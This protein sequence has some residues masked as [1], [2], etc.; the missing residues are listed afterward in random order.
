MK[1]YI[2]VLMMAVAAFTFLSAAEVYDSP[3]FAPVT[4]E[5]IGQGGAFT[6]V[7]HGYNALFTNPAGF[8]NEGGSF[9]LL[10]TTLSPY[11]FPTQ[12]VMDGVSG[13][14]FS[15][16]PDVFLKDAV[17]VLDD[18][19]RNNGL[20][21]NINAGMAIVGKGLGL[22]VV[23]DFDIYAR[24]KNALGTEVDAAATVAAIAGLAF[25][26]DLGT[27]MKLLVGGDIRAMHRIEMR[28]VTISE[29]LDY[30]DETKNT[31]L[32]ALQGSGFAV[33]LGTILKWGGLSFGVS[34]RDL[35]GTTFSYQ[36]KTLEQVQSQE[37]GIDVAD[38]Y[39]IP[40]SINTGIGWHPNLGILRWL[41]DPTFQVDYEHVFYEEKD[42][43]FWTGLH[44]GTEI[45]VLRFI[46]V[47]GG[48]NQGYVTAGLGM[49][50]L[51]LDVNAS[52]F[53][54]EMGIYSGAKPNQGLTL[55]AAIRF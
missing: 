50:L 16:S 55:E 10:S 25:T 46:K 53:T 42:P 19:L 44:A 40:M 17:T 4:P 51:F 12:E 15:A 7:A 2:L 23:T 39:V 3:Q 49:K 45:R 1:K 6:A 43:T 38:D 9:T 24:G 8:A 54:R 20:G 18:T 26:F 34:V 5:L 48:I 14:D 36:E 13:V 35:G 29:I 30:M 28:D 32:Y 27:R 11:V 37:P 31:E 41:I 33:D 22:G 52:Y 21:S 47:R